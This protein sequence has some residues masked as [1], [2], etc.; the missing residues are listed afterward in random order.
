MEPVASE[1]DVLALQLETARIASHGAVALKDGYVEAPPAHQLQRGAK[2]G[3]P[4]AKDNDR[5]SLCVHFRV[6]HWT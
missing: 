3:R 6:P 1:I 4:R 2:A 5:C